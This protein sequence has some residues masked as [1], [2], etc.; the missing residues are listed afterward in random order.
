VTTF[1]TPTLVQFRRAVREFERDNSAFLKK[2]C[3]GRNAIN[4][5]IVS[6]N[7]TY[8]ANAIFRCVN[9]EAITG[10]QRYNTSDSYSLAKKMGFKIEKGDAFTRANTL[11]SV[12]TGNPTPDQRKY[13]TNEYLRDSK[14]RR[15]VAKKALGVCE[16]CKNRGFNSQVFV[17]PNGSGYVETHHIVPVGEGGQDVVENVIA[18]CPNHHME[19]HHGTHA[20][21]LRVKFLK[22]VNSNRRFAGR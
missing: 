7:G 22:I 4:T 17:K 13:T 10:G 14:V 20:K 9:H 19:A 8:P 2:Y 15:Y 3:R 1:P 21:R 18:L 16:C 12:P 11:P 5:R 6:D